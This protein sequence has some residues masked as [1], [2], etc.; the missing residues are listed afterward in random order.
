MHT[1]RQQLKG[2]R[3]GIGIWR[4]GWVLGMLL[5]LLGGWQPG[6]AADFMCPA[7]DVVCLKAAIT[8][9]NANGEPNT[10]TLAA[11]SYPLTDVVNTPE[12]PTGLP[13]ITSVLTLQG[14]G[15]ETTRLERV[16][17]G[18]DPCDSLTEPEFRILHVAPTG[19]LT[20][21]GLTLRGGCLERRSGAGLSGG[22]GLLTQGKVFL[23]Q[24]AIVENLAEDNVEGGGGIANRGHLAIIQSTILRNIAIIAPGAG[25][26]SQ[27]T[28]TITDST[29]ADNEAIGTG[30]GGID[31]TGTLTV[32]RSRIAHNFGDSAGGIAATGVTVIAHSSIEENRTFIGGSGGI[33]HFDGTMHITDSTI[34]RNRS[35]SVGGI[36]NSATLTIHNSTIAENVG[37]GFS[38]GIN[39]QGGMLTILNSTI[40]RNRNTAAIRFEDVSAGIG[41]IPS[42]GS[43]IVGTVT[44]LNTLV[45]QNTFD[46]P[47][48]SGS[49]GPD[50]GGPITS[51]SHNLIGDPM[52]CDIVLHAS[53]RTGD[54]RLR[55]LD[56]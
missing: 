13:S 42:F 52:G 25:I 10:I 7:G 32:T 51:L 38:G 28:V 14:A 16:F 4:R 12:G 48:P 26:V 18:L 43:D 40:A 41:N 49:G 56:R 27:G 3:V 21:K 20:L 50:C 30:G 54:P 5:S 6:Q 53:D 2:S 1:T 35:N 8:T 11:G 22:G 46:E 47:P 29:I 45:A 17:T 9:A 55:R 15:A 36:W 34:A 19:V 39:N 23:I 37:A 44:V 33:D 31:S 24:S